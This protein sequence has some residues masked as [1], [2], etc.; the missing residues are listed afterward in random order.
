M[1]AKRI[2]YLSKKSD[3]NSELK[4]KHELQR[5]EERELIL[6]SLTSLRSNSTKLCCNLRQLTSDFIFIIP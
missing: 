2:K 3:K 4:V 5:E 1:L 6:I